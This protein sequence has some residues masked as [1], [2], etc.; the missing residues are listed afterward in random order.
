M[1]PLV[2][3]VHPGDAVT[4][5]RLVGVDVGGR[6]AT[7]KA[8]A[9]LLAN[10]QSAELIGPEEPAEMATQFLG[11]LWEGLMVG[12]LLGVDAT[13][14]PAE[15]ERRAAKATAAFMRLHPDPAT[16]G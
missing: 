8:L 10:A 9:E 12:M 3:E 1:S 11:L 4:H 15:T 16:G 6:D 13:P 2:A 7:R 5:G 14:E